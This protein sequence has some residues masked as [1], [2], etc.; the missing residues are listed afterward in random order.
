MGDQI[1]RSEDFEKKAEKKLSGW[2]LFG[3]KYEDAADIFDKAGNCLKLAKSWD[4]A[5]AVYIKLANCHLKLDSKF[6]A[7]KAYADAAHCYKKSN[8]KDFYETYFL[9]YLAQPTHGIA[10]NKLNH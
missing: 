1:A 9:M 5:G 4:Q 2:G 3:S 10:S 7:V 6:E 8:T